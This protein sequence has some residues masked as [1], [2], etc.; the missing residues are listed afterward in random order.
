MTSSSRL[1]L[2][3]LTLTGFMNISTN[4]DIQE[5]LHLLAKKAK[6]CPR[7]A[8]LLL[9][10]DPTEVKTGSSETLG[11]AKDSENTEQTFAAVSSGVH[12]DPIWNFATRSIACC[13][14]NK[15]G[16]SFFKLDFLRHFL[17]LTVL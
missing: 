4:T 3:T 11:Y 1:S 9:R 16:L 8:T 7:R 6:E 15:Y 13:S 10:Q 12:S 14:S 2:E 5:V 17:S